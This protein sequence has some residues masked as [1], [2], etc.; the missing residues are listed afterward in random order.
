LPSSGYIFFV[1]LLPIIVE[2]AIVWINAKQYLLEILL[3]NRNISCAARNLIE[4]TR[5]DILRAAIADMNSD[6]VAHL[7]PE[8]IGNRAENV[9]ARELKRRWNGIW[10]CSNEIADEVEYFGLSVA[11]SLT[12]IIGGF[13]IEH[14][15]GSTLFL[16]LGISYALYYVATLLMKTTTTVS[17]IP[18]LRIYS[19]R[20]LATAYLLITASIQ[21]VFTFVLTS[22][23]NI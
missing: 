7:S 5:E 10:F 11:L 9:R 23:A 19:T 2:T 18:D 20:A 16:I 8:E 12:F 1:Q 13:L 17:P 3:I 4:D 21:Y 15:A 6:D 14:K 22:S